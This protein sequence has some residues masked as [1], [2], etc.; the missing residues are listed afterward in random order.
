MDQ[1]PLPK[2]DD[3]LATLAGGKHFTKLDLKQA[4]LQLELL[5]EYCT[6]KEVYTS[7]SGH[8]SA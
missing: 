2:V 8:P 3:L 1:Y 6:V 7:L 4:Y 5:Q